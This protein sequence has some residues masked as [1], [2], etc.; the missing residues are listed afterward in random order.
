VLPL[1]RWCAF[2]CRGE[3]IALEPRDAE[4]IYI[5]KRA[6]ASPFFAREKNLCN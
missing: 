6:A 5:K 3:I 4:E 2:F 1:S